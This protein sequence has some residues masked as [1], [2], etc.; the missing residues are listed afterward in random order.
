MAEDRSKW[1]QMLVPCKN[2]HLGFRNGSRACVECTRARA[3]I[4]L[5]ALRTTEK[6]NR[7]LVGYQLKVKYRLTLGDYETLLASQGNRCALCG[8]STPGGKGRFHVDHDHYFHP[9][10]KKGH[11]GLLCDR[12]NKGL[13]YFGDDPDRLRLAIAYLEKS[14]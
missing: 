13:G 9:H 1:T 3:K 10:D 7:A 2:G 12:C 6:G 8:T 4:R 5:R 11:R 14:S